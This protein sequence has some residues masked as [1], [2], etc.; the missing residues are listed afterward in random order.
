MTKT[1]KLTLLGIFTALSIVLSF[2]EMLLPPIYA[3]VPGVKI[4]L[5][6]IVIIFLLYRFSFKSAAAVSL[7][8]VILVSLLF[9]NGMVFIYSLAGAVLSLCF[10]G[11]LKKI[12]LFSAV[13]VSVVGAVAHN[14]GQVITAAFLMETAE[15]GYYMIVLSISGTLAGIAVGLV[16]AYILKYTER[17]KF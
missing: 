2:V 5:A 3:A 7:I 9:A 4:G 10:M 17:F 11:I 6:N 12:N 8:R 13:G 1:K 16:S 14:L 15:I